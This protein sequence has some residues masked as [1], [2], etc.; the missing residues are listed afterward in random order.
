MSRQIGKHLTAE[1]HAEIRRRLA[2]RE[3]PAQIAAGM[4]CSP[5]SVRKARRA[6]LAECFAP[7]AKAAK[8]PEGTAG[9][10]GGGGAAQGKTCR[11][12]R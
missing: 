8:A 9:R 10:P 1:E 12:R 3:T 4:D 7:S 6:I 11:A 2:A 5:A